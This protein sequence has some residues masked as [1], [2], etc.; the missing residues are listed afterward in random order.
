MLEKKTKNVTFG[1]LRYMLLKI[2]NFGKQ[3]KLTG[4]DSISG[5]GEAYSRMS[6]RCLKS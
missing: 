3:I 6:G 4:K 5:A 1:K 2:G